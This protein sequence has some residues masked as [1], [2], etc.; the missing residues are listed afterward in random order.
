LEI[1]YN[2]NLQGF[3]DILKE[4]ARGID[5]INAILRFYYQHINIDE[6]DDD[7][8]AKLNNEVLYVL[9]WNGTLAEKTKE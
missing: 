6:I 7:E 4:E 3:S 8:W 5:K 1:I 2:Y 9:K